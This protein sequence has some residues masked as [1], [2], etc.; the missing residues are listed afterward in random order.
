MVGRRSAWQT[1]S[2]LF[3]LAP[4]ALLLAVLPGVSCMA[5][6]SVLRRSGSLNAG[7]NEEKG[8]K[9]LPR[10][11][12][13]RETLDARVLFYKCLCVFYPML[14]WTQTVG[15][16]GLSFSKRFSSRLSQ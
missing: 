1:N 3:E 14:G 8:R 16:D 5:S 10:L 6:T 7:R 12:D 11:S 2:A 4:N 9:A 13:F 15:L